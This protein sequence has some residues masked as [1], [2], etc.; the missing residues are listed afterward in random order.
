LCGNTK[1][2]FIG[3]QDFSQSLEF[4]GTKGSEL[5][6]LFAVP[7]ENGGLGDAELGEDAAK[8]GAL[9]AE[10]DELVFG[11]DGVHAGMEWWSG[12]LLDWWLMDLKL[13]YGFDFI[14][15]LLGTPLRHPSRTD[16]K[17]S[18]SLKLAQLI[19]IQRVMV[20]AVF[21]TRNS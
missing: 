20:L 1:Q 15:A 9:G 16:G 7:N 3:Q 18:E 8:P 11:F 2:F 19:Q 17:D 12:G 21:G 4:E 6:L 13:H 14:A 5:G 10:F